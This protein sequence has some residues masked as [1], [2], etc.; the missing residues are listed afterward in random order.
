MTLTFS[1]AANLSFDYAVNSSSSS[2]YG[3]LVKKNN[4]NVGSY[5]YGTKDWTHYSIDA[6]S[7]DAIKLIFEHPYV[8]GST[9]SL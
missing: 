9:C 3:F 6:A 4:S 2:S 1:H 5:E 8:Y 7:G